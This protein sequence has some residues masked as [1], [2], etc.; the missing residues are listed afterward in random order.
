MSA[1]PNYEDLAREVQ[2]LEKQLAEQITIKEKLMAGQELYQT[3]FEHAGVAIV[4]ADART[5]KVVACNK[6]AY[7]ELGYTKEEYLNLSHED[8]LL[9][10]PEKKNWIFTNLLKKGG[11][12]YT[13]KLRKKNGQIMEVMGS[14]VVI[15]VSG[16]IYNHL[17][18][19]DITDQK[20]SE[21]I[22][23]ESEEKHHDFLESMDEGYFEVDLEGTFLFCNK[24]VI[25]LYGLRPEEMVGKSYREQMSPETAE[26]VY[27]Y[28][29]LIYRTGEKDK[30]IEYEVIRKDGSKILLETSVS[31]MRNGSGDI[32]GFS[33]I[34]RDITERKKL[35]KTLR[36]N[37]ELYRIIF[38]HAGFP[39]TL[40]DLQTG[41]IVAYNKRAYEELG[42]SEQEF[43]GINVRK[44]TSFSEEELAEIA[45]H[46]LDKGAWTYNLR[47]REKNGD[48]QDV[49]QSSVLVT[50]GGK[51]YAHN[52]WMDITEQKRSERVLKESE[53]RFRS[54]FE[55][56]A[57][58]IFLSN[59]SEWKIIDANQAACLY[60]G[61]T[62]EELL[63]LSMKD[64]TIPQEIID[65]G[66]ILEKI[67]KSGVYFYDIIHLTKN[68]KKVF[69][70]INSRII[71]QKGEEVVLSIVR[72]VTERKRV[73]EELAQHRANLEVL[74]R[75][76]TKKL[77]A[78]QNELIKQEKLAVLGQ[79]TATVS[80]ELR[81]PLG[82]IQSS[83]YYLQRKIDHPDQEIE[84]HFK[85]V[86]EQVGICDS[87]VADLLEYTRGDRVELMRTE[88]VSWLNSLL[89]QINEKEKIQIDRVIPNNLPNIYYDQRKLQL[90][91]INLLNNAVQ[92]V[93]A[94]E[95][96]YRRM[97]AVF[98][99]EI[100][101]TVKI[102]GPHIV[103]EIKDNGIGMDQK[104]Q[105]QAFDPLFTTRTRGTGLGLA[106]VQ[107]I[108]QEHEG[109]ISLSSYPGEGTSI[110]F[111]L[112]VKS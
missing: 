84:Q 55:T 79:L 43:V 80:H 2:E 101:L 61:Y 105:E 77:E 73:E 14:A 24:A 89:D 51:K 1:K 50:F 67:R 5:A 109:S 22:L 25:K 108:V 99:P 35:E 97:G 74:V 10:S 30:T 86:D 39:M 53:T 71:E 88:V 62:K 40:T 13:S 69:A 70:E 107:K 28:F 36:E 96:E 98:H 83:N 93:I 49:M 37:E 16:K 3:L 45:N 33:G 90:V 54:I 12:T 100:T 94:K 95:E 17:I 19:I 75:E 103:F 92:A 106:N 7:E 102:E 63:N 31:L 6:K 46:I 52:I 60:L 85:Q 66:D 76:R 20:K 48:F 15:N 44:L 72:D 9:D 26:K 29:N 41:E 81:N 57:D 47:L 65:K 104:T 32:T 38:E 27:A 56:A 59:F 111:T 8:Y 42:Y 21:R 11:L 87:I 68:S 112:P 34:A 4:I 78:A 18:R 91:I 23:K 82:V 58:P 110:A 64:M